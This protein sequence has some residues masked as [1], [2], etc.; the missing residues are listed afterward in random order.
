MTIGDIDGMIWKLVGLGGEYFY[1]RLDCAPTCTILGGYQYL[2]L[3]PSCF[4]LRHPSHGL[5]LHW[6]LLLFEYLN[7]LWC[8]PTISYLCLIFH[9]SSTMQ[10][11]KNCIVYA[12]YL[13][14]VS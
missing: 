6:R 12:R 2:Y 9:F 14:R 8:G 7:V 3:A 10:I 5:C 11:E 13:I 1:I 4:A